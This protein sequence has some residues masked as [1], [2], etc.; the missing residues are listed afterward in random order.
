MSLRTEEKRK[1]LMYAYSSLWWT[2]W[3]RELAKRTTFMPFS[4]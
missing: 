4:L 1:L 3:V 2:L